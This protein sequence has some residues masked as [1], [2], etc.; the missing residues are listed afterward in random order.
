MNLI[1]KKRDV[2]YYYFLENVTMVI[3]KALIMNA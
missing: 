3:N 1:K 2:I